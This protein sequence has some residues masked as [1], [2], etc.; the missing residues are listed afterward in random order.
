MIFGEID[1][2]GALTSRLHAPCF[3]LAA[4]FGIVV[5]ATAWAQDTKAPESPAPVASPAVAPPAPAAAPAS[6]NSTEVITPPTD[7][8]AKAAFDVLERNCS[9]CHQTGRLI[10][11]ERPAKQFGNILKLDELAANPHLIHPGN[12]LDSFLVRQILDKQMPY[13]VYQEFSEKYPAPSEADLKALED[14]V[15]GLGE[16]AIASCDTHKLISPDDMVRFMVTDLDKQLRPRQ[17]TTRYL[18]LTNLANIC[19]DPAAMKVYR[20]AA[21]KFLNSLGRSSD[22]VKLETIDPEG[23]ILRFDL[24]DLGW[25]AADWDSLIAVYPY[26]VQ[27][28]SE[29]S[30]TLASG[31]RTPQP[32]VRADWFTFAAS[33]P[34]LYN[35]LLKL[36]NTFQELVREQGIDV[37]A[38]IRS[39]VAQRAAFQKSGVSQNN[40]LIER[41]PSRSG[42]FWTSYDFAGNRDHQSL[43]DFPLG[44]SAA[45]F[46][47]DG[48]ETIFSLPNGFQGYYLNKATGERL[49]KGPTTIVRD[50][51]RKDFT[52]TNGV[53]CMGCHDQGMR[54]ARD[55]VRE[56]VL[57]RRTFPSDIRDAVDGLYP[58]HDKMDALIDG[59]LKRFTGAMIQA[60]LDPA[61]N[62]N[63][64]EMINALSKRYEDDVDLTLA[65]AELGITKAD[66]KDASGDVDPKFRSLVRRLS[67]SSVP[68][69]QFELAFRELAPSLTDLKEVLIANARPPLPLAKPVRDDLALTSD[70]DSYHV[71]DSPVFSVVSARDCYLSLTDVDDKGGGTVLLPNAFQQDNRI[72]AGVPIQFPGPNAPFK[73]RMKDPGTETIVA[74]CS[75]EAGGG[76]R[77]RHD[78]QRNSF[79]SV[80][81]Y[82]DVLGRAIAVDPVGPGVQRPATAPGGTPIVGN[83]PSFRAAIRVGV[84]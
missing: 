49:D 45:G 77:I 60:G 81:N 58:P 34:P 55:E 40:R 30:R 1:M 63:G 18:T 76:D 57:S 12:P 75:T 66:F 72:T 84:R 78:F 47:H 10:S 9:R 69:D 28:D 71:G 21:I 48:G 35:V 36:P 65:A 29:L 79:T 4:G 52:V 73:F 2:R 43:F 11:R 32:Y 25:S 59:D 22:V 53:S 44:P 68:R 3:A 31:T 39:F 27:P 70:A 20:Q 6:A 83:R 15:N 8:V 7:P 16:K 13:D 54:K 14:W 51:S 5:A 42:Y 62:L 17:S 33:Q 23:T 64:I 61:L 82:N 50:E 56:F 24:V 26:N 67:Q 80:S 41:H 19:V 74:V 37:E 38:D 46:H